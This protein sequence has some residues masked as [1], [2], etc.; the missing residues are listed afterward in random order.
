MPTSSGPTFRS[1]SRSECD[2]LLARNHVGRLAFAFHDRVDIQPIHYVYDAGWLFGRTS[3]GAKL[4]TLEHNRWIA[5]E[6]DEVR[7]PFD[8][9]SVVVQGTFHRIDPAGSTSDRAAAARAVRLLR[10]IVPGT[11]TADDPAGFRTVLFRIAVGELTGRMAAPAADSSAAAAPERLPPL[12][13][14]APVAPSDHQGW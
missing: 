11:F 13:G 7:G 5:F 6:V 8:W 10:G 1:L 2:A 9:A 14:R 4:A 3:E 12:T